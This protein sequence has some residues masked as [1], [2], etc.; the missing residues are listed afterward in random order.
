MKRLLLLIFGLLLVGTTLSFGQTIEELD[1]QIKRA[2]K[3]IAKNEKLLKE[4][5]ANKKNN[6]T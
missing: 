3:E 5:T 6:Q 4:V 2:E 1:A